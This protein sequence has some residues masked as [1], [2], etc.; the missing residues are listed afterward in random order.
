MKRFNYGPTF[1]M[2]VATPWRDSPFSEKMI[3]IKN[4]VTNYFYLKG[5]QNKK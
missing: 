5:K 3:F 1:F 4:R 2:C